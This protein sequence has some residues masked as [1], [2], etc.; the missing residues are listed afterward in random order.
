[1]PII[2][3]ESA[4]DYAELMALVRADV[5]PETLQEWLLLKDIVDAE[6]ELLRLRGFKVRMLHAVIPGVVGS[7]LAQ[8]GATPPAE[9]RPLIRR[10]VIGIMTGDEGALGELENLLFAHNL[11]LDV[12]S[13]T[14]FQ[15]NIGPQLK[16]DQMIGAAYGRRNAAYAEI[17]R[18]RPEKERKRAMIFADRDEQAEPTAAGAGAARNGGQHPSHDGTRDRATGRH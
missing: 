18:L 4:A 6:W 9:L 7:E 15:Q 12:V 13:A 17:A 8:D 14:A 11:M 2:A 1:M 16:T 3:G 10:H 5:E